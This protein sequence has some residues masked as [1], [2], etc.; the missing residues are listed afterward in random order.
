[1]ERNKKNIDCVHKELKDYNITIT[2]LMVITKIISIPK[3][4][5][6]FNIHNTI[7]ILFS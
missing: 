1:M 5:N 7:L 2:I 4:Y 6:V 3:S